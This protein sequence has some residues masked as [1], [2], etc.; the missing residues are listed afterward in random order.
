MPTIPLSSLTPEERRRLY[1]S[2]LKGTISYAVKRIGRPVSELSIRSISPGDPAAVDASLIDV[3]FK[4]KAVAKEEAWIEAAADLTPNALSEVTAPGFQ[5]AENTVI[6]VYGFVDLTPNPDLTL[7]ALFNG[8]ENLYTD[9]VE[10]CYVERPYGGIF[11][12][13]DGAPILCL[14]GP[15]DY[16]SWKMA[17]KSATDK[18]VVLLGFVVEPMGKNITVKH[19]G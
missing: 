14:W 16:L 17:F 13:S 6:G 10:H 15:K 18:N 4:T 9:Q 8:K 19:E 5:V 12:R 3:A 1:L 2:A 11:V 7:I